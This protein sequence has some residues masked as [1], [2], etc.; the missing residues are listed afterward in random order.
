MFKKLS[1]LIFSGLLLPAIGFA[2]PATYDE[3]VSGDLGPRDTETLILDVGINRVIGS[4]QF[5]DGIFAD[6]DGF[7][8]SLG[9]GLQIDSVNYLISNLSLIGPTTSLGA[10]YGLF[11]GAHPGAGTGLVPFE[12]LDILGASSQPLFSSVLPRSGPE[13]LAFTPR[14]FNGDG[15]TWDYEFQINVSAASIPDTGSALLLLA[16]GLAGLAAAR[17]RFVV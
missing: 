1:S 15:G 17:R 5:G 2:I 9:A 6:F 16:I 14:F 3:S 7:L 10:T 11:L 13:L 4:S 8:V 12:G